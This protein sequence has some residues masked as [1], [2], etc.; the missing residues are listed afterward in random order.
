MDEPKALDPEDLRDCWGCGFQTHDA[1]MKCPKCGENLQSRRGARRAGLLLV[2]I[3][4]LLAG[5]CGYMLMSMWPILQNP[6]VEVG[7]TSFNGQVKDAMAIEA[8]IGGV[9]AFGLASFAYGA[10]QMR[11]GRRSR[12]VVMGMMGIVALLYVGGWL[13]KGGA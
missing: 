2:I 4:A 9:V 1:V 6:G 8:L 12:K 11:T 7:G 5:G 10:W 13:F 3:G